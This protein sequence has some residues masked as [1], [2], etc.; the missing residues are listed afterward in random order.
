MT[1][2]AW[3]IMLNEALLTMTVIIQALK[4]ENGGIKVVVE[5][6]CNQCRQWF[7]AHWHNGVDIMNPKCPICKSADVHTWTDETLENESPTGDDFAE[8]DD[9]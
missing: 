7:D 3:K 4:L 6:I 8:D 2:I 1:L 5:G 9:E